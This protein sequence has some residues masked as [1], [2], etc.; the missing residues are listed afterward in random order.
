METLVIRT[1]AGLTA[2]AFALTSEG[3]GEG[4]ADGAVFAADEEVDVGNFV[5][6]AD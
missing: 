2:V 5:A 3:A 6:F 4:V 1:V